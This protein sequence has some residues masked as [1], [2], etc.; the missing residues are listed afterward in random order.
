MLHGSVARVKLCHGQGGVQGRRLGNGGLETNAEDEVGEIVQG[1]GEK[2]PVCEGAMEPCHHMCLS[3]IEKWWQE[4]AR[5]KLDGT[6]HSSVG[7]VKTQ[8]AQEATGEV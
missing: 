4:D 1:E 5:L 2:G 7:E 8:K 6:R 3:R